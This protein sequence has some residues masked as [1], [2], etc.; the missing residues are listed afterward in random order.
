MKKLR[1][2]LVLKVLKVTLNKGVGL[3]NFK[4]GGV[5]LKGYLSHPSSEPLAFNSI[6]KAARSRFS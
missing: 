4:V 1:F 6:R 3:A 2:W 5:V